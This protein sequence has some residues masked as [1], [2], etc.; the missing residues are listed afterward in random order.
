M[1]SGNYL[2]LVYFLLSLYH[3]QKFNFTCSCS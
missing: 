2:H 3:Y 1:Y